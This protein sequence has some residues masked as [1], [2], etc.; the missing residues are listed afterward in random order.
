MGSCWRS[1][2][3]GLAEDLVQSS[4]TGKGETKP[5][6]KKISLGFSGKTSIV[7]NRALFTATWVLPNNRIRSPSEVKSLANSAKTCVFPDPAGPQ[8]NKRWVES[9]AAEWV[10]S[11]G[12]KTYLAMASLNCGKCCENS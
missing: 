6:R 10:W 9:F 7:R 2:F 5:K 3:S 8:T 4:P 11:R 1:Q 12:K